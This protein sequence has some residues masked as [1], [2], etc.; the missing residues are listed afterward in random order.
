MGEVGAIVGVAV[1]GNH[2]MV[3]VGV[4]VLVG[5]RVFSNTGDGIS[6]SMQADRRNNVI[7]NWIISK[8]D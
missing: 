4:E 3:A 2:S 8:Q 5:V 6:P 1:A 7:N